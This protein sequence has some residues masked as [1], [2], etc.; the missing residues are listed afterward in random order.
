MA[1]C[2]SRTVRAI[3]K[4]ERNPETETGKKIIKAAEQILAFNEKKIS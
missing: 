2:S 4:G 3:L 1:N